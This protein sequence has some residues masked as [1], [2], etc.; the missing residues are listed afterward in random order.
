MRISFVRTGGIAGIRLARDFDT[1]DLPPAQASELQQLVDSARFFDLPDIPPPAARIPDSL[2]YRISV[3]DGARTRA[4]V[5][6]EHS[7]PADLRPLITYLVSLVK[8]PPN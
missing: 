3:S 5:V 4:F 8:N 7:V 1:D 2:E 6:A